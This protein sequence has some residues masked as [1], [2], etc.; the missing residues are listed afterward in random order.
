MFATAAYLEWRD[1][2][3]VPLFGHILVSLSLQYGVTVC[4]SQSDQFRRLTVFMS[5]NGEDDKMSSLSRKYPVRSCSAL[6][7]AV[8]L[9]VVWITQTY[10]LH[11]FS[12]PAASRAARIAA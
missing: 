12:N 5:L 8:R 1:T 2:F 10:S 7:S 11:T 3:D 9:S 4:V 6:L